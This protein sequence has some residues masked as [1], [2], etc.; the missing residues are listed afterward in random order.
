MRVK[1]G[2]VTRRQHKKVLKLTEGFRGRRRNCFRLAKLA[3]Q[4][5][6]QYAYRD[7]R[8]K[9]REFRALWIARV[10]AGAR[11]LGLSYSDFIFG[12]KLANVDLNRKQ[13]SELAVRDPAAFSQVA[14]KARAA[15]TAHVA[16]TGRTTHSV[17]PSVASAA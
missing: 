16:R 9:K 5:A 7:R 2:V 17:S 3:M 14:E 10:G 11:Q 12:L 4:K 6:L 15:L 1:G 13:L 8:V